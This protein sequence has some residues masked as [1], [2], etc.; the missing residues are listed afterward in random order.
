MNTGDLIGQLLKSGMARGAG[1]RMQA[2]ANSQPGLGSLL[3]GLLGGSGGS[4]VGSGGAGGLGG[5]SE[6]ASQYLGQARTAAADNP[7]LAA[8]GLGAVVGSLLGGGKVSSGLGGAAIG[9]IGMIA[10]NALRSAGQSG[11]S[12]QAAPTAVQ[13]PVPAVTPDEVPAPEEATQRLILMAMISAAK[14]DGHID[15]AEMNAIVGKLKEEGADGEERDWVL[16]ELGKPLDID[17]LVAAVPGLEVAAQVYAASILAITA[18]TPQEVSYLNQLAE[19][20]GLQ[21]AVRA[22]IHQS[23]GLPMPAS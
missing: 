2:A 6:L 13:Q 4:T 21:P 5:L 14:A 19:K 18:D 10:M 8:G 12:G 23:L 22:Y 7:K 16:R 9:V 20:L 11:P 15:E 3:G 1:S 17:V